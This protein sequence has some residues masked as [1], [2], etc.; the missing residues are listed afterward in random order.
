MDI[1]L[2][3]FEADFSIDE[4]TA[5]IEAEFLHPFHIDWGH[6]DADFDLPDECKNGNEVV[7]HE[8]KPRSRNAFDYEFGNI[9]E[10]NWYRKILCESVR[11]KT[12][13]LSA[14][15]RYGE[16]RSLFRMP[17]KKIDD[18][19]SLFIDSEWFYKTKHCKT[20][21]EM[22]IK[23][24]LRILGALKVISHNAPFWTLQSNTNIS[25]KEHRSFFKKFIGCLYTI[26]E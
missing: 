21:E 25:D 5:N 23:L 8:H 6:G 17:L 12:Y 10:A 22:I 15:D 24:K 13:F 2:A 11:E 19:V 3:L 14:Q 4:Y 26:R 16:F 1:N 7:E 18:M 9:Y 20:E